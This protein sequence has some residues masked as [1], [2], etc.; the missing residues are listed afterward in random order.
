MGIKDAQQKLYGWRENFFHGKFNKGV[1]ARTWVAWGGDDSHR[2]AIPYQIVCEFDNVM[3][4]ASTKRV[5]APNECFYFMHD[6]TITYQA[7]KCF[8]GGFRKQLEEDGELN[9][10]ED[11]ALDSEEDVRMDGDCL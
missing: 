2:D 8:D 1:F 11:E 7:M 9:S 3:K 4:L 6:E 10:D 5:L